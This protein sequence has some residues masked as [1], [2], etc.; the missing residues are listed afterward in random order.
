MLISRVVTGVY[1][2][3]RIFRLVAYV[4]IPFLLVHVAL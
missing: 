1:Y 4:Y 2:N 3:T